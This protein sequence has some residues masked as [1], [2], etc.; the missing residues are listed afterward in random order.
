MLCIR[1]MHVIPGMEQI[2]RCTCGG[3][4]SGN[5]LM[6][7]T[8]IHFIAECQDSPDRTTRHNALHA[9]MSKMIG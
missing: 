7:R 2:D 1:L 3:A 9:P 8:G 5:L 4:G 6:V